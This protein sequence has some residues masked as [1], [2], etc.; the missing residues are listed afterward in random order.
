M[1][2]AVFAIPGDLQTLTGGYGYDRA[3]LSFLPSCGVDVKYLPLP[4][5]FPFPDAALCAQA[6][7]KLQSVPPSHLLLVDG[8]ALGALPAQGLSE[9]RAPLVAL[10]HHPLGLESGLAPEVARKLIENERDVLAQ[11]RAVIVTSATTRD[12]LISDF[13]VPAARITIAEPGTEPAERASGSGR[14]EIELLSVGTITPRKGHVVL[15]EALSQLAHLPWHLT[16]VGSEMRDPSCAQ[17]LHEAIAAHGLQERIAF[18]GECEADAL[19][20]VYAGSDLFIL[21]SLYEGYGMVLAEAMARGL[22]IIT[23]TGGAA[24]ATVPDAAALKV[25]PGD[26]EALRAALMRA[27]SDSKLRASLSEA[28]WQAAAKL[29]SWQDTANSVAQ[30]LKRVGEEAI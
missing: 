18:T 30:C 26:V 3:L 15:V 1:S 23:T 4:E 24:A 8:L 17:A 9:L 21:P 27:L 19:A 29:P 14:D 28:S 7:A 16:L 12:T 10:V 11:A 5:G 20:Q 13:A 25:A 6:L 2:P 22:P